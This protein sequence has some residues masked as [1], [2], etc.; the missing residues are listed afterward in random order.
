[1]CCEISFRSTAVGSFSTTLIETDLHLHTFHIRRKGP[2]ISGKKEKNPE[3]RGQNR[4][5]CEQRPKS[6]P[7]VTGK[8][9]GG[10]EVSTA[11]DGSVFLTPFRGGSLTEAAQKQ[12]LK[13]L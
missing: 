5:I 6:R 10:M 1:M 13:D 11:G 12:F 3:E 2:N 8:W 7:L 9:R 4:N